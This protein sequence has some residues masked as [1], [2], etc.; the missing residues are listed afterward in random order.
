MAFLVLGETLEL[1]QCLGIALV[2]AASVG[3]T[4]S[5]SSRSAS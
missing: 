5:L 4:L 1:R 2:I 3:A